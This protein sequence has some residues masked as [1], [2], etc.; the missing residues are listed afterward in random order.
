MRIATLIL[1]S[2]GLP[3]DL[4]W[5]DTG[6]PHETVTVRSCPQAYASG[7]G[8]AA[9][10]DTARSTHPAFTGEFTPKFL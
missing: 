9:T 1:D 7:A 3:A 2:D 5:S 10:Q 8:A 6:N 4:A